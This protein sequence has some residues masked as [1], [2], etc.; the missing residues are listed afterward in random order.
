[1][2]ACVSGESESDG[3]DPLSSRAVRGTALLGWTETMSFSRE[4]RARR[5]TA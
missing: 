1:M 5:S 3:P 4:K 2:D